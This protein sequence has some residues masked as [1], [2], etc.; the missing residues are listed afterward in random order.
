MK[1]RKAKEAPQNRVCCCDLKVGRFNSDKSH[2]N[3][4]ASDRRRDRGLRG[5]P[6]VRAGHLWHVPEPPHVRLVGVVRLSELTCK[7][8]H[9]SLS[10][11]LHL[12]VHRRPDQH[13]HHSVRHRPAALRHQEGEGPS[14]H[15]PPLGPDLHHTM[16]AHCGHC[17]RPA[18]LLRR[19]QGHPPTAWPWGFLYE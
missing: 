6:P 7:Y 15:S 3:S 13:P 10:Q 2:L 1:P 5:V 19:L 12:L 4:A 18:A 17:G 9:I 11:V 8:Y 14:A 16:A